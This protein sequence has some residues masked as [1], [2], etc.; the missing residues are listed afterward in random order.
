MINITG[1]DHIVLRTNCIDK[2]LNFY[3]DIL[4]C[5]IENHQKALRL[6]QLRVGDNLIDLIEVDGFIDN[7]NPNMEHFCLRIW[8]FD[9]QALTTYFQQHQIEI[10]R[11]GDRYGSDGMGLSF[12]VKDPQGNEIELRG[13]KP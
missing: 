13:V 5:S 2:M 4:G 3:C 11:Y 6:T 12:Y 10:L 7:N 8:P 9:F 1:I